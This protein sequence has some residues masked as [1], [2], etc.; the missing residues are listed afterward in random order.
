MHHAI[1]KLHVLS[2]FRGGMVEEKRKPYLYIYVHVHGTRSFGTR[3]TDYI[4]RRGAAA[5]TYSFFKNEEIK[6]ERLEEIIVYLLVDGEE[7]MM[8]FNICMILSENTAEEIVLPRF[9]R[10]CRGGQTLTSFIE[11][12]G[13][14]LDFPWPTFN[15]EHL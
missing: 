8:K 7:R 12:R 3:Q 9:D 5:A 11:K 14:Q 15:N 13:Q 6:N 10:L 1:L 4:Y 2:S